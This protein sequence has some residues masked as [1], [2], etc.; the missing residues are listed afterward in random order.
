[1]KNAS[2]QKLNY[3][4]RKFYVH[5][6]VFDARKYMIVNVIGFV[7]VLFL[8]YLGVPINYKKNLQ[9]WTMSLY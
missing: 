3:A 4:Q 8:F 7:K 1:M 5:H 9:C 2:R 6:T